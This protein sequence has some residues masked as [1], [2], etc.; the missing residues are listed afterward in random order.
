MHCE[1]HLHSLEYITDSKFPAVQE[2]NRAGAPSAA[3]ANPP[4][5]DAG[6]AKQNRAVTMRI[7]FV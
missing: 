7:P 1:C 5:Q 4:T 6:F 3:S 2:V